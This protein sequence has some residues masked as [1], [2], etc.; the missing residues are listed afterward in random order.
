MV[1][2]HLAIFWAVGRP[3]GWSETGT[4]SIAKQTVATQAGLSLWM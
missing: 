4:H 3:T 2:L 1:Y